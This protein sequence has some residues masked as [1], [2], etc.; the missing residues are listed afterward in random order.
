MKASELDLRRI[1]SF[2]PKGGTIQFMGH[3]ALI[4]DTIAMGLM[5]KELIDHL[6]TFAARNILTRMGYAHG[7]STADNLD[8]EYEGLLKDINCGP[9][10]HELQGVVNK[11]KSEWFFR[12]TFLHGN[13]L[14][15]FL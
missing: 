11:A 9:T 12:P 3:R 15:G 1:L 10:L 13:N 4:I 2:T 14:A 8:K 5:R 6:G 7:W